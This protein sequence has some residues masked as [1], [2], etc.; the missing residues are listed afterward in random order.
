MIKS[1][2][3]TG[4]LLLSSCAFSLGQALVYRPVNPAF[5]GN[6][7][8]YQWM[9]GS[10]QAQDPNA[11]AAQGSAG[12]QQLSQ[13]D[14][15]TQSLNQQLLS[16]ISRQIIDRQFGEEGLEEGDFQFGDFQVNIRNATDGI[17]IRIQD[18]RGGE[19]TIT[20]PYF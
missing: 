1:V 17:Q 2:L 18:G 8:N 3:F 6:N 20:V 9:I 4:M 14:N 16:R 7:F 5:G 10:A 19:T 15:F 13:L 12:R 11:P